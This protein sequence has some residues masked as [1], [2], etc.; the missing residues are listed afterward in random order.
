MAATGPSFEENLRPTWMVLD[1]TN[2]YPT[3][4]YKDIKAKPTKKAN[5]SDTELGKCMDM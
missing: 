3:A 4:S 5:K 2:N 1:S